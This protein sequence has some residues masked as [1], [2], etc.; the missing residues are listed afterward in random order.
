MGTLTK[1][2]DLAEGTGEELVE[3]MTYET[4]PGGEI[5]FR[6]KRT[7]WAKRS[8][9][10]LHVYL[11]PGAQRGCVQRMVGVRVLG[12]PWAVMNLS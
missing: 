8:S 3:E 5:E 9:V 4:F 2:F 12:L 10:K 6:Q 11:E 7:P 1:Q